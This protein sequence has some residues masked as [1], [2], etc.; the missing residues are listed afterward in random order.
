ME[1]V[2]IY[3]VKFVVNDIKDIVWKSSSFDNL[4]IPIKK[5]RVITTLAKVYMSHAS[6]DVID[7]FVVG[8]GQGLI[9]LLQYKIRR[10]LPSSIC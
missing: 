6:G 9:T 10:L 3:K 8:K 2:L 4:A 5:K 7:D 1:V